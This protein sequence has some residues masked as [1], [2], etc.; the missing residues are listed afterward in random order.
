MTFRLYG[1]NHSYLL[2]KCPRVECDAGSRATAEA[3]KDYAQFCQAEILTAN[4][5][6]IIKRIFVMREGGYYQAFFNP[7]IELCTGK[8]AANET[9]FSEPMARPNVY[10]ADQI[11]VT[12]Q[13]GY[14]R[15]H[16]FTTKGYTSSL[17]Q[18]AL[19]HLEG[20]SIK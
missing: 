9:C 2:T 19:D 10:R 17:I 20:R 12:Y 6:G 14:G 3:L 15:T 8:Q 5:V 11:R 1:H 7:E 18:H 16:T 4:Q 13:D